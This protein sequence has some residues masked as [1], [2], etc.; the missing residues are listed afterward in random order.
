[1][2]FLIPRVPPRG[3]INIY[4]AEMH[5]EAACLRAKTETSEMH[6]TDRV[7][8]HSSCCSSQRSMFRRTRDIIYSRCRVFYT[9]HI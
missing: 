7:R 1:M 4:D 9:F 8:F 6:K 3:I 5:E 2:E